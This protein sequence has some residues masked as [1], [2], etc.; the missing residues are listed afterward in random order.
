MSYRHRILPCQS[1]CNFDL[2][3]FI[4]FVTLQGDDYILYCHPNRQKTPRSDRLREWYHAL[5]RVAKQQGTVTYLSNLFDTFF[6]GGKDHKV[7]K[8][9]V[10]HLPYFDGKRFSSGI[11]SGPFVYIPVWLGAFYDIRNVEAGFPCLQSWVKGGN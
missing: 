2:Q 3:F 4:L 10:Q 11:L 1:F 9:S 5:L 8:V 6:E 7:E